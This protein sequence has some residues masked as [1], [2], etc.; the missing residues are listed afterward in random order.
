MWMPL[1]AAYTSITRLVRDVKQKKQLID[2]QRKKLGK[3]DEGMV[4]EKEKI[5]S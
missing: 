4:A 2:D 5:V 1:S 3:T